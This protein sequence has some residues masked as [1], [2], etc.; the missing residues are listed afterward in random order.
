MTAKVDFKGLVLAPGML[1]RDPASCTELINARI[2]ARGIIRKRTGFQRL[3]GVSGGPIWS[4]MT[5]R[6]LGELDLFL[7]HM[8]TSS[9]GSALRLGDGSAALSAITAADG[10]AVTRTTNPRLRLCLSGPAHY[11]NSFEGIRRYEPTAPTTLRSAGMPRGLAPDTYNMDGAVYNVIAPAAGAWLANGANAAYRVTWHRFDSYANNSGVV[12]GGPPTG[13]LVVRNIAG[14]SGFTGGVANVTLRIPLP[15]EHGSASTALTTSYFWRLWRSQSSTTGTAGDEMYLVAEAFLTAGN[16]AAGYAT[17]TDVTPDDIL[18][19]NAAL[20]TNAVNVPPGEIPFIAGIDNADDPPPK[21]EDIADFAGCMFA[22]NVQD[23]AAQA[24]VLT[25]TLAGGTTIT[26]NGTALTAVVGAPAAA[27]FTTIGGLAT[28]ALNIEATARNIVEAAN[29]ISATTGVRAYHLTQSASSP[30]IILFEYV[31][32]DTSFSLASSA[33]AF[34]PDISTSK[35]FSVVPRTNGIKVSK[36]GRPDAMAPNLELSA[37]PGDSRVL[38]LV[39]Q[40]DALVVFTDVGL[41]RI[42][43]SYPDFV[44]TEFEQTFRLISSDL[45]CQTDDAVYAWGFEGIAEITE[46]DCTIISGPIE[47]LVT[48][49][50]NDASLRSYIEA[51]GFAVGYRLAHRAMFFYNISSADPDA[52]RWL[53]YDARTKT[54]AQGTLRDGKSCGF[55]RWSD[56]R[57]TMG[58]WNGTSV[59]AYLFLER[60]PNDATPYADAN[61]SGGTDVVETSIKFQFQVPGVDKR[62]HWRDLLM[63]FESGELN[64]FSLPSAMT[65]TWEIDGGTSPYT[66]AASEPLVRLATPDALARATRQQI[67]LTHNISEHFGLLAVEQDEGDESEWAGAT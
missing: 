42:T 38:R 59:D 4:I 24:L 11:L 13:R 14:S 58:N 36:P 54:W 46:N 64:F 17:V 16:I 5:S 41:Y 45:V 50:L 48:Y 39:A 19:G 40:R 10:L 3:S 8:G 32:H 60:F 62:P 52:T 1:A 26:I 22:G 57:L 18:V 47:P 65:V 63:Q 56:D 31:L 27:Q 6:V 55:V 2:P 23:R 44:V 30:G 53:E 15:Y 66:A 20:H 29:R 28:L 21:A 61:R 49:Y 34:R 12:Y 43:G 35:T 9:T 25:T 67:Q 51:S 7:V 33:A 37:G